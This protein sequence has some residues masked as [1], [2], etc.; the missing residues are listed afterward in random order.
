MTLAKIAMNEAN[1][2][3]IMSAAAVAAVRP[4]A[5][6]VVGRERAGDAGDAAQRPPDDRDQHRHEPAREGGDRAEQPERADGDQEQP[7]P[8]AAGVAEHSE[9]Q[10]RGR[11]CERGEPGDQRA[12]AGMVARCHGLAQAD[13]RSDATCAGR[14]DERRDQRDAD[15]HDHAGQERRGR[16]RDR[17]LGDRH[18]DRVEQ[19]DQAGA[20]R[21]AECR[22]D[23]RGDGS[24]DEALGSTETSAW[25]RLAPRQ[26]RSAS[27]RTRWATVIANV[28]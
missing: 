17:H 13:R 10:G 15:A 18:P 6:R 28:L 16:D 1:A 12:A 11:Q 14:R 2:T 24:D 25:R 8:D 7:R 19:R 20:Q 26:R 21:D 3:P 27:S 4:G 22:A 9:R 23:E 5:G